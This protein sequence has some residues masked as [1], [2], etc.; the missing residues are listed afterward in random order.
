MG[1]GKADGFQINGAPGKVAMV[2]F[3][4]CRAWNNS[5]DGWDF[6]DNTRGVVDSCWAWNNG[7]DTDGSGQGFKAGLQTGPP[8][9]WFTNWPAAIRG[10]CL[11]K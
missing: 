3:D 7:Y 6:L 8:Q 2:Y 10:L 11:Y 9:G 4:R 1:G 5:D